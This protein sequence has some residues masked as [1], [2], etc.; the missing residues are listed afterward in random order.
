M[1]KR[2]AG[3]VILWF[4]GMPVQQRRLAQDVAEQISCARARRV[5]LGCTR[6]LSLLP[7]PCTRYAA[8]R[9]K[10]APAA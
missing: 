10:A 4:G 7:I 2:L 6:V 5:P 1:G 8:K 9:R 3:G